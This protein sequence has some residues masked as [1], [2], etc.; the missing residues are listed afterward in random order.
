MIWNV[1]SAPHTEH[2]IL[3]SASAS[4]LARATHCDRSRRTG[5]ARAHLKY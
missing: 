1:G 4:N 3:S 5:L 2:G